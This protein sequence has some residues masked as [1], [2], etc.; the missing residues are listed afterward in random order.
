MPAKQP[1]VTD[2]QE[3]LDPEMVHE[4]ELIVGECVP[5]IAGWDRSGGLAAVG[6]AL[7]HRDGVKLVAE[8]PE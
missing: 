3:L 1:P 2:E 8:N 5:W 4:A 7:I 6:V